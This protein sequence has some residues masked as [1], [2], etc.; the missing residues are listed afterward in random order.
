M[1][2]FAGKTA[3]ITGASRGIGRAIGLDLGKDGARVVVN[4]ASSE[5]EAARVVEE[6]RAAGG[7]A[8]A[9]QA[10]VAAKADVE[11]MLETALDAFGGVDLLVNNAGINIDRPFLEM[12]EADWDRVVDTNLKGAFLCS[13]AAGRAMRAAGGGCIVNISAVTAVTGRKEAANYCASKAGLDMLTKCIALELAPEVRVNGLGVGYISSP[14]VDALFT[15]AQLAEIVGVT[16]LQRMGA[17]EE[18]AAAV[19][20][21]ASEAAA[22]ITGQTLIVD[23]GRLMR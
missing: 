5:S 21:F 4:Y 18:I 3:I 10:D 2:E 19:R 11:R 7:E 12:S 14:T 22:F 17:Y 15:K 9:C 16:P 20:F 1:S 23:G 6:V 8:V 13:Q